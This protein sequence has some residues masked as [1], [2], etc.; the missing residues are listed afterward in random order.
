MRAAGRDEDGLPRALVH[1]ERAHA[2]RR[3]ELRAKRRVE[4]ELLRVDRAAGAAKR[5][6]S[7]IE[8]QRCRKAKRTRRTERALPQRLSGRA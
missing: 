2:V 5:E 4:I 8:E 6:R 7:P 1:A 3:E